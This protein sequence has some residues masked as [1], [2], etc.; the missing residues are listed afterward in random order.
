MRDLDDARRHESGFT[1]RECVICLLI[2]ALLGSVVLV[3]V[4]G[5]SCS[6]CARAS[7][8]KADMRSISDALNLYKIDTGQYPVQLKSL[9]VRPP[10]VPK[11]TG[12]YLHE[13]PPRDPW[14][15]EYRY[16]FAGGRSYELVSLGADRTVGCE[17]EDADLS[18]RTIDNQKVR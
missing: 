3:N 8:V 2:V 18:S 1:L 9:W 10:D 16:A 12:P 17:C 5:S 13:F 14:G 11:W 4:M 7:R 15:D 6:G